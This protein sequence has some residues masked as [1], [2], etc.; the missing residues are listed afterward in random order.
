MTKRSC[1]SSA[2][3]RR[4]PDHQ[5]PAGELIEVTVLE[6]KDSH[7]RIGTAAPSDCPGGVADLT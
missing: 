3:A 5:K 7:V 1:I 6:V 2:A 4:I